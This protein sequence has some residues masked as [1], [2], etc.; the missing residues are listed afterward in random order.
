MSFVASRA[1]TVPRG[2]G[3][4]LKRQED[5]RLI[6]GRG[7][8]GD[9]FVLA[10]QAYAC[11]VRS[12]HPHARIRAIDPAAALAMPG[13]VAVLTGR[14]AAADGL[15]GIPHRPV[16]T[17]PN[18]FPLGGP[19]AA[20]IFVA[21]YPPLPTDRARFVGEAVAM[22]VAETA[23]L[24]VDAAP[25][26]HVDWEPLASVTATRDAA[27][28][29]APVLWE[30][31][32][33]N[34]CVDSIAGDARGADAAFRAAAHVVRLE[35]WVPR[36]TGVPMEPRAALGVHDAAT[37]RFTLYAGADGTMFSR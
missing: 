24:A 37:G 8:F 30:G 19:E 9:D 21:P 14:D 26:V 1:R 36:V 4:P 20:P 28:V 7:R 13:V 2:F 11:F 12:P 6:T 5:P 17:N 10:G 35:T 29:G 15:A 16:P 31:L 23:A 18:E 27:A 33:R 3:Q 32:G 34:V 25:C 22:V